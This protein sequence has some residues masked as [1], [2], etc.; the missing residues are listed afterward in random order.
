MLNV[1]EENKFYFYRPKLEWVTSEEKA[2][3]IDMDC[4]GGKK[5]LIKDDGGLI[6]DIGF[7][8]TIISQSDFEWNG[9]SRRGLGDYRI[10]YVMLT[11]NDG[12]KRNVDEYAPN[13]GII[14]DESCVRKTDWNADQCSNLGHEL[15]VFESLDADSMDRR[16][17]PVG[18]RSD[19]GYIDLLNGP[20]A[21]KGDHGYSSVNRLSMFHMI[22]APGHA[23]EL[24][25]T[26]SMPQTFRLHN[27]TADVEDIFVFSIFI[28]RS[29][30]I[31]VYRD[32]MLIRPNN[33]FIDKHGSFSYHYPHPKYIPQINSGTSLQPGENYFDRSAMTLYVVVRNNEPLDLKTSQTLIINMDTVMEM[34]A[35]E[36]YSQKKLGPILASILNISSSNVKVKLL[37]KKQSI[38]MFASLTF[39]P[40][41]RVNLVE[42]PTYDLTVPGKI[43]IFYRL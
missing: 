10:P 8:V 24:A 25:L 2:R 35:E 12:T 26:G 11:N 17:S 20:S 3:C 22:V 23:Y 28:G 40:F 42:H 15:V 31:E 27:P 13:K 9:D 38:Y 16:V 19:T 30:R 41:R 1:V 36:L 37:Y 14:R 21:H 43:T 7:P 39:N 29:Q 4:D 6:D 32:N 18:L 34:T 33:A 5:I